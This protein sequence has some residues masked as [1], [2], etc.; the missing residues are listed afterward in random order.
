MMIEREEFSWN[1]LIPIGIIL[2]VLL[3]ATNI[4]IFPWIWIIAPIAAV[5]LFAAVLMVLLICVTII[6]GLIELWRE[7]HHV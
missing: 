4:I 5:F 7:S 1:A 2:I 6:R 3:R